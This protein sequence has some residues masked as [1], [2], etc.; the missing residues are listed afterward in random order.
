MTKADLHIHSDYSDGSDG[1]KELAEKI[2]NAGINIFALTDHDE[3][4]GCEETAKYI[5]NNIR[6][7]PG[8]ELTCQTGDIKCHI[9]GLN[10]DIKNET[11]SKLIAKGKTLRKIKLE[12]RIKYLEDVWD[13]VLTEKEKEW[14]YSRKS[15][16]KT[17]L[18]NILVSR[19]LAEENV[20]AMKKYLDGCKAGDKKFDIKEAIEAIVDAGGIPIWAHPLGGEGE[21]HIERELFL[22]QLNVMISAGIRG[23]EC[24]YSRYSFDEIDFLVKTAEDNDL[25]ISGGSDYHG[26]NKDITLCRLNVEEKFIDAE[27]LTVLK[28]IL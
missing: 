25:L 27:K 18:A 1:I 28:E 6:F 14:L 2:K 19:G 3:N 16:V 12:T 10:C 17:H 13:I 5:D 26:T 15:V 8:I 21:V 24:Y 4:C 20:P 7:I 11:M 23:L 22:K 9:L